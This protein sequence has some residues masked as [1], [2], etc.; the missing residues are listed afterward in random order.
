MAQPTRDLVFDME[1]R[2]PDDFLTL[3]LLLGHRAVNLRAVT[4]VPGTPEQIGLVRWAT[5]EVFARQIPIGAFNPRQTKS[6][7]SDWHYAAYGQPRPA[8]ARS[9]CEVLVENC[10]ANTTLVTGAP[11]RNLAL[12]VRDSS[13]ALGRW[14]AQGGFAGEGVVASERQLEKF[15]GQRTAVTRNLSA[16]SN[17]THRCLASDRIGRRLFVSKK[18]AARPAGR[19]LRHR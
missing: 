15:R 6:H 11:L 9:G 5:E 2:D 18:N 10:D 7:V 8:E 19:M 4:V 3:L 16:H 13:F 14:V 12:A 1:T 17:V